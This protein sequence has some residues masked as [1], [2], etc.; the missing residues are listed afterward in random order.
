MLRFARRD[1]TTEVVDLDQDATPS[2]RSCA[3]SFAFFHWVRCSSSGSQ[4]ARHL[5]DTSLRCPSVT[6]VAGLDFEMTQGKGR[7]PPAA[8]DGLL[9]SRGRKCIAQILKAKNAAGDVDSSGVPQSHSPEGGPLWFPITVGACSTF[10]RLHVSKRFQFPTSVFLQREGP[11][12]P[13]LGPQ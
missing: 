7:A 3:T 13:P 1:H 5:P 6:C 12:P 4:V 11:R 2:S 10:P 9:T 8:P